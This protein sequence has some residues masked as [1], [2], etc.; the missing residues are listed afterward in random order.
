M[1]AFVVLVG[2]AFEINVMVTVGPV[3]GMIAG[4]VYRPPYG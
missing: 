1:T 2:S 3:I 4:A